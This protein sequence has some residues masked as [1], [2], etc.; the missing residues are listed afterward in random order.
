M[1]AG[2]CNKTGVYDCVLLIFIVGKKLVKHLQRHEFRRAMRISCV[3]VERV[4]ESGGA[5][6]RSFARCKN[7]A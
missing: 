3:T 6:V 4:G 7:I 1:E 5:R 2:A